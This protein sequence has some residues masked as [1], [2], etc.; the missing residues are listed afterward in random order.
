MTKTDL[1]INKILMY[2]EEVKVYRNKIC[3]CVFLKNFINKENLI[4][5]YPLKVS[6][7]LAIHNVYKKLDQLI[8]AYKLK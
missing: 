7:N 8:I 2:C 1:K 5:R 3:V 6:N 4:I